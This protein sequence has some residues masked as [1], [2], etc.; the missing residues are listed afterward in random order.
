M[1]V[2]PPGEWGI[3]ITLLPDDTPISFSVS[4][5]CVSSTRLSASWAVAA[6]RLG[7]CRDGFAQTVDD[8]A[9][10]LGDAFALQMLGFRFGLGVFHHQDLVRFALGGRGHLQ[11]LLA[12]GF[13]S[14]RPSRCRLD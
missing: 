7:E 4:K 8:R 13:R 10:L 5:Y 11:A 2:I 14:S 1:S 12:S 6:H 3:R 9:A